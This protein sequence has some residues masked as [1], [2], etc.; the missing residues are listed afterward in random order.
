MG[1][2]TYSSEIT[3]GVSTTLNF[4]PAKAGASTWAVG[5]DWTPATGD[6]KVSIDGGSPANTTNLPSHVGHGMWELD[7][8]DD[9][10]GGDRVIVIIEDAGSAI[11][12]VCFNLTTV[13]GADRQLI[14]D[15]LAKA[16]QGTTKKGKR[17]GSGA[18]PGGA[19]PGGAGV[20]IGA[21]R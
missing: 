16:I 2:V 13:P 20:G 14:L 17:G 11:D 7:L 18:A 8:A 9:E 21:G 5:T 19:L 1:H 3:R 15:I 12:G 4:C 6:S 10:T